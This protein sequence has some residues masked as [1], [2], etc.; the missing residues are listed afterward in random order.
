MNHIDV[1][2]QALHHLERSRPVQCGQTDAQYATECVQHRDATKNL[3]AAIEQAGEQE[4][5][6]W[7]LEWTYDGEEIGRRIYADERHCLIDAEK[8]GGICRPLVF[9]DTHPAPAQP[10]KPLSEE[11]LSHLYDAE[12]FYMEVSTQKLFNSIARAIE[13]AHGIKENS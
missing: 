3:R 5:V 13:A 1:M 8:D 10:A 12:A 9:G 4:H 7:M 2:K 6:A 11:Q